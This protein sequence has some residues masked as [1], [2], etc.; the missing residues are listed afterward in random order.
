MDVF[1][2]LQLSRSVRLRCKLFSGENIGRKTAT[3]HE[4]L[5][6]QIF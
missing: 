4:T 1:I 6:D 5:A 3:L 2:I